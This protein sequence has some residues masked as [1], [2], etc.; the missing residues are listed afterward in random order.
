M[1]KQVNRHAAWLRQVAVE[2]EITIHRLN[3][4]DPDRLD[5]A[6]ERDR[7]LAAAKEIE[8]LEAEVADLRASL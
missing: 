7:Y 5:L 8:D 3:D 4:N 1:S 2:Y 6:A